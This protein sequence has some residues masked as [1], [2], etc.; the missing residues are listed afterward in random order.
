[1]EQPLKPADLKRIK[2]IWSDLIVQWA[3][4]FPLIFLGFIIVLNIFDG[5]PAFGWRNVI[6]QTD[7][8]NFFIYALKIVL[9]IG[10]PLLI[11]RVL[12]ICKCIANGAETL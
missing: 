9:L 5:L 7:G 12:T 6:D 11:W 1:M 2:V 4:I 10:M 8:T 3:I